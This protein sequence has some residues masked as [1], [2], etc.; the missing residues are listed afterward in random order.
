M[1][2]AHANRVSRVI[3]P[4]TI[5]ILFKKLGAKSTAVNVSETL[6]SEDMVP[7][8]MPMCIFDFGYTML[9]IIADYHDRDCKHLNSV[10]TVLDGIADR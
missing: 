10:L 4:S 5:D 6:T 8:G 3:T 9:I 7:Q 2:R 1:K